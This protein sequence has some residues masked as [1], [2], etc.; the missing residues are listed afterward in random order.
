MESGAAAAPAL[1]AADPAA[2]RIL[3]SCT[4]CSQG[5]SEYIV[6]ASS[7][8]VSSSLAVDAT[9]ALTGERWRGLFASSYVEEVT[10]RTGSFKEFGV[11]VRMLRAALRGDSDAVR[12]DLLTY[13][14][15]EDLASE[16]GATQQQA[17]STQVGGSSPA[18]SDN[19]LAHSA[20]AATLRLRRR[21]LIVTYAGEFDSV[22]Y[23]LPLAYEAPTL[24]SM[25]E[26]LRRLREQLRDLQGR[27]ERLRQTEDDNRAL[28]KRVAELEEQLSKRQPGPSSEYG[29]RRHPPSKLTRQRR[30][31]IAAM[32]GALEKATARLKE[33]EKREEQRADEIEERSRT[34]ARRCQDEA[35]LREE[36]RK[37]RAES[38][39]VREKLRSA[40]AEA[41]R[42]HAELDEARARERL[43]ADECSRL[44]VSTATAS[45]LYRVLPTSV[46]SRLRSAGTRST[47]ST[48]WSRGAPPAPPRAPRS[49]YARRRSS[50]A[51]RLSAAAE[52]KARDEDEV[53]ESVL[54]GC[55]PHAARPQLLPRAVAHCYLSREST[56][57]PIP[58]VVLA[59]K[60]A[61]PRSPFGSGSAYRAD[62]FQDSSADLSAEDRDQ[63]QLSERA[64]YS[65]DVGDAEDD[66]AQADDLPENLSRKLD[67]LRHFLESRK[68]RPLR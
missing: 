2:F 67:A 25:T 62:S 52:E 34:E 50:S 11:F 15:L 13:H 16:G 22:S 23:P 48:A 27:E 41:D 40:R 1:T 14:D 46:S 17:A 4:L 28:R 24:E 8:D 49:D 63:Q 26:A 44:R 18:D 59:H 12:A 31:Q 68:Q 65:E 5:G 19:I 29:T 56:K 54:V 33:L 47:A 21:Y 6:T 39:A 3:E 45:A 9:D 35:A 42:L 7:D 10:H 37:A 61:T 36:A 32:R 53:S 43:L 38:S 20:A 51:R 30:R 66:Q 60:P 55:G 57:P 58:S 64:A